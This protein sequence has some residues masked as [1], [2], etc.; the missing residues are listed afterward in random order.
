MFNFLLQHTPLLYLTQSLWRDEA[1]SI[2]LSERNP[3][4]FFSVTFEPPFYYIILHYWMKILGENEIIVRC[5]SVVGFALAVIV[6]I[7]WA[8][9]MFKKHWLSWYLPVFFF[10]NP[11]LL[12][13]AFEIRAYGWYM[14]F[15]VLSL[16]SYM[17]KKWKL[18]TV[19]TILGL[20]THTYMVIVPAMQVVHYLVFEK[21]FSMFKR[22]HTWIRDPMVRSVAIIGVVFSPW[23]IH[24]ANDMSRLKSSWYYPV[25]LQLVKSVLGNI[26][27]GYEGTPWFLWRYTAWLSLGILIASLVAIKNIHTRKRNSIFFLVTYLP[28]AIIIGISFIKPLFVNRYV[29]PA[30]IAEIFLI[31]L[32]IEAIKH[33]LLQKITAALVLLFVIGFNIWYPDQHTKLDIRTPILQA[34]ALMQKN[35]V[36]M[37]DSPLVFFE[38]IYYSRNRSQVYLYNPSGSPFPWY[39]GGIIVSPSQIVPDLPSYPRRAFIIHANGTFEIE[40]NTNITPLPSTKTP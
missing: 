9:K 30:T 37:A 17:E 36:I 33:P 25:D 27:L 4:S 14:F 21:K 20:F 40:Y 19:S 2:L 35:D 18:Y 29:M 12:Y 28:L 22:F 3:I 34:N 15:T 39:I 1:F 10:C 38:T 8:E 13:Y 7:Y 24:V 32:A 6:V 11:M 31:V 5:L 23:L 16:Y 26:F